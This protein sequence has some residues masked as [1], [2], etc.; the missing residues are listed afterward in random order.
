MRTFIAACLLALLT[1]C[2]ALGPAPVNGQLKTAY[3][4]VD[5]YV[6]L[7]TT[8]L[9]R[10]R[11]TADEARKASAQAKSARDKIDLADKALQGC[12]GQ[13]P[14]DTYVALMQQLQPILFELERQARER[15][16]AK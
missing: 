6:A 3:E 10:G 1:A 9:Q 13:T 5:A 15:E 7:T 14:C 11:I 12:K 8:S 4:T 2:G 16:K